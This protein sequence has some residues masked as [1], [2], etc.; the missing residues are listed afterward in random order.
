MTDFMSGKLGNN[1]SKTKDTDPLKGVMGNTNFPS[2]KRVLSDSET[3]VLTQNQLF[4]TTEESFVPT[5]P[6]EFSAEAKAVFEAGRELWKYYFECTKNSLERGAEG[7]VFSNSQTNIPLT[8]LKGGTGLVA[9]SSSFNSG[10]SSQRGG[11]TPSLYDIKAYFQGVDD[12]G[13]MNNKS[14]DEKYNLLIGNLREALEILGAKIQ[15]KVY[16]FGFLRG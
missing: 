8:A 2:S 11:S 15:L 7:G 1:T 9:N 5:E 10:Y 13:R 3:G 14:D 4:T 6:L 16:K 12:K